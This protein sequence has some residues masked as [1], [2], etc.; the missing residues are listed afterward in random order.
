MFDEGQKLPSAY[1]RTKFES[2]KIAVE[3]VEGAWRVYNPP[4][5]VVGD[6]EDRR[7]GQD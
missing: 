5:I 7:D 6:L 1:H 4:G 2:E 3:G